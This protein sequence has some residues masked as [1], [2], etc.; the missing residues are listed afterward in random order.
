MSLPNPDTYTSHAFRR[1]GATWIADNTGQI[2]QLK[3]AGGW[4][5]TAVAER[6]VEESKFQ[7]SKTADNIFDTMNTSNSSKITS[8]NQCHQ[9]IQQPNQN[10][11][12]TIDLSNSTGQHYINIGSDFLR[13]NGPRLSSEVNDSTESSKLAKPMFQNQNLQKEND[14]FNYSK[15]KEKAQAKPK[16]PVQNK[17]APNSP[18]PMSPLPLTQQRFNLTQNLQ[19]L[20]SSPNYENMG[21]FDLLFEKFQSQGSSS[22]QESFMKYI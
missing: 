18:V 20:G 14:L 2:F 8:S 1:T 13:T 19:I 11:T 6:Y 17:V 4:K 3:I 16:S 21:D 10:I 22:S 9:Q 15:P 12:L 7:K 5:S